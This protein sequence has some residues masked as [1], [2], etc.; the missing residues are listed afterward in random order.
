[1]NPR[2]LLLIVL[3]SLAC[4]IGAHLGLLLLAFTAAVIGVTVLGLADRII[5][6][7]WYTGW[8][9]VPARPAR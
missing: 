7:V 5:S 8:G 9:I 4:V 1:M 2:A 3:F 6:V